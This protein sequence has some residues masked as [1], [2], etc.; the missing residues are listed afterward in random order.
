MP[1]A[2]C[3]RSLGSL[4][5]NADLRALNLS[6]RQAERRYRRTRVI[7]DFLFEFLDDL[8]QLFGIKWLSYN[9]INVHFLVSTDVVRR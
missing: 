6:D 9:L 7:L 1:L 8:L 4:E 2:L 5:A 3:V